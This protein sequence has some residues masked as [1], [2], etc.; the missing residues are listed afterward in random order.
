VTSHCR[1]EGGR[2]QQRPLAVDPQIEVRQVAGIAMEQA[3][4]GARSGQYVA[5]VVEDSK[6]VAVLERSWPPLL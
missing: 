2:Q 4:R 1:R 5:V 6:A 3:I